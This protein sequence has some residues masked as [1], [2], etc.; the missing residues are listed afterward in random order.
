M[1][2]KTIAVFTNNSILN[3]QA[4]QKVILMAIHEGVYFKDLETSFVRLDVSLPDCN[5]RTAKDCE[6]RVTSLSHISELFCNGNFNEYES[7]DNS[8]LYFIN[9]EQVVDFNIGEI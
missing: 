2:N 6:V 3:T 8:H 7:D 4:N 1:S 5:S 9:F